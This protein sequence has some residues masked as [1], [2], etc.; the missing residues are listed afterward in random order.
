MKTE[1]NLDKQELTDQFLGEML[2][3]NLLLRELALEG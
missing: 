2:T 3:F 1:I